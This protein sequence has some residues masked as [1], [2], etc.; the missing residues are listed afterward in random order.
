MVDPAE[1][2]AKAGL[3]AAELEVLLYELKADLNQY[4]QRLP[5]NFRVHTLAD[6]I[7]FNTQQREREM[8]FFEQELFEQAQAKGPLTDQAY[9]KARALCI[10]AARGG[11]DGLMKQHRLDAIVSITGGPA[12]MIDHVNGDAYTGSCSTLP[13]VAGYPHITVPAA[14]YMKLPIGLSFFGKAFSEPILI[15]LASS[16]ESIRGPLEQLAL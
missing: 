1:I 7:R 15:K 14:R 12:W 11:I 8:P 9:V 3:D 5:V 4:L 2:P 6:I 13:A 16:F 10:R